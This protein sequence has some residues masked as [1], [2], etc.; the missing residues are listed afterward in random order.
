MVGDAEMSI[1]IPKSISY[2][3]LGHTPNI[4]PAF[5]PDYEASDIGQGYD[6]TVTL[7]GFQLGTEEVR[8]LIVELNRHL[9]VDE[10]N[11]ELK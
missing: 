9:I 3:D 5:S 10:I 6:L 4:F 11:E 2:E 7:F 8:K 1:N